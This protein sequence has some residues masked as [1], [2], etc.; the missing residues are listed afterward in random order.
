ML[1]LAIDSWQGRAGMMAAV[2]YARGRLLLVPG[3]CG[4]ALLPARQGEQ[5]SD[6]NDKH[7]A[8]VKASHLVTEWVAREGLM[9]CSRV[10][11]L[12]HA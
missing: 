1:V 7:K 3:C 10:E 6:D 9:V 12:L 11:W 5:G 8:I 4:Y 2:S